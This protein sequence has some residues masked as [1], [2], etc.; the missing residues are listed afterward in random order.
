MSNKDPST[1]TYVLT[2]IFAVVV[3]ALCFG[4]FQAVLAT[5]VGR[6]VVALFLAVMIGLPFVSAMQDAVLAY[7]K[8]R[9]EKRPRNCE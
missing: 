7:N 5:S 1:L 3:V 2:T 4:L 9:H 8:N 6:I